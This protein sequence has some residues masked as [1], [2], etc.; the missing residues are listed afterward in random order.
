MSMS[1]SVSAKVAPA[2]TRT[3][4][5]SR[6]AEANAVQ[7]AASDPDASVW[8][9]A[10]AGTGKTKVLTDRLIRLMLPRPDGRAGTAAHR[11]LCL[12][13]TKAGAGEMLNRI[14]DVLSKWAALDE[15]TLAQNLENDVLGYA[16]TAA[17]IAEARKLFANVID[18]PGGMNIMT[19]H[20]FCQSV[21]GR[22][23]IESGLSPSF[24]LLSDSESKA[25]IRQAR[26]MVLSDMLQTDTGTATVR[27]FALIQNSQETTDI[28][29]RL[30]SSREKLA[31]AIQKAGGMEGLTTKIFGLHG[32]TPSMT[33]QDVMDGGL[34]G[35]PDTLLYEIVGWLMADGGAKDNN[36]AQLISDWLRLGGQERFDH[37]DLL[38]EGFV[39]KTDRNIKSA[40]KKAVQSRPD[41]EEKCTRIAQTLLD[42][43]E[44]LNALETCQKTTALLTIGER[45]VAAYKTLKNAQH[46]L[47]YDD[48]IHK[49][50]GLLGRSPSWVMF[51]LDGG[52]EH[53][54]VDEA[55]DTNAEQWMIIE[56]LADDFFSIQSEDADTTRTLFVVGDEKQSIY[57]FQG[58]DPN[59]FHEKRRFFEQKITRAGYMWRDQPLNISF[60]STESVL[61]LVDKVFE[62]PEMRRAVTGD[63]ARSVVHKAFREGQAGYIEFW[64]MILPEKAEDIA[65]WTPV[66]PD[67]ASAA[68]PQALLAQRIALTVRQWLDS[69]E[70]LPA[71]GRPVRAGDVM[72]LVRQRDSFVEHMIRALKD[73]RIPVNGIDRMVLSKQIAVQDMIAA[74]QFA[75][76]PQDDLSLAVLL[77]SPF[78]GFSEDDLFA[79]SYGRSGSLWDSLRQLA[80]DN[81]A[82][83]ASLYVSAVAWLKVLIERAATQSASDFFAGLLNTS[84]PTDGFSGLRA[85]TQRLGEDCLDPL[86]EMMNTVF[87]HDIKTRAMLQDFLQAFDRQENEIKREME[88][89]LDAVRIMTVH[90]SKGLQAPIVFLPDTVIL[91]HQRSKLPKMLWPDGS[92]EIPVPLWSNKTSAASALYQRG[93]DHIEAQLISE[94]ERLLYVALT[95]AEDRLYICGCK[96]TDKAKIL[97]HSWYKAI[98]RALGAMDGVVKDDQHPFCAPNKSPDK[99]PEKQGKSPDTEADQTSES[100]V[101][102]VR[103][104][105]APHADIQKS[106][107]LL[108]VDEE[109]ETLHSGFFLPPQAEPDPPRPLQPSRPSQEDEAGIVA[110]SP[111][112][113]TRDNQRFRRGLLIHAMLQFLPELPPQDRARAAAQYLARQLPDKAQGE[114]QALI[115]EVFAITESPQYRDL[116]LPDTRAE[117]PITG[118]VAMTDKDGSAKTRVVS[119]QIDRLMVRDDAVWIVDY[120]TNRPP[121][122][123]A[124][125]IPADYK[126]QM[127][128]YRVLLQQ[129]YPDRP[130][131]CFLLWT[132]HARI[133]EVAA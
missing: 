52:L 57:S 44:G 82:P 75:L 116:F 29:G 20:A 125:N 30:L 127:A 18:A 42:V 34:R 49:T 121:P 69:G 92:N 98:E 99:A 56:R 109:I 4:H 45:V 126:R 8:V 78:I 23:P 13:Y 37:F 100:C 5:P 76:M 77:K 1:E 88:D 26:D 129:I 53:I 102:S 108:R 106:K 51:K 104:D 122:L 61:S 64:P 9:N 28:L 66:D 70:S 11:I 50:A 96:K 131:R 25:L 16:P 2:T 40:V 43:V 83:Y 123:D 17:Q 105:Q 107:D 32:M 67:I 62:T 117:V 128:C 84:C 38:L 59:V 48:L 35:V 73:Q 65:P 19:I 22:F 33:A 101:L 31:A 114:H 54:L 46:K 94:S 89:S 36:R 87:E 113:S 41:L 111:L 85:L 74:A 21:L 90:G 47:D 24:S 130:V 68:N 120:K 27:D 97:D 133:M 119:G 39:T 95:R 71:R 103:I 132:D 12:T 14:M 115:A 79:T 80:Q 81:K 91:H 124:A 55:Q 112:K 60:R 110:L 6:K 63:A 93:R 10:S 58:A 7:Q 118:K 3:P 86:E 72:I 15:K